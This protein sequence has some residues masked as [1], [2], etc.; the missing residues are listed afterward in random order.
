MRRWYPS[1][2]PVA[3]LVV[4]AALLS[5]LLLFPLIPGSGFHDN[6]RIVE[7]FCSITVIIVFAVYLVRNR[8]VNR[9]GD[10]FLIGLLAIFFVLGLVSSLFAYST[11]HA[12]FEWANSLSLFGMS[13]FIAREMLRKGDVFLDQILR[14]CGIGCVF[15]IFVEAVVYAVLIASGKQPPNG[16]LIFGFDNYRFFNHVQTVTLPLLCLWVSRTDSGG[17][18]MFAW[19]V[20]SIWWTLLFLSTGRGTFIGVLA[21]VCVTLFYFRK[22]AFPWCRLMLWTALAGLGLYF[23]FYV[24]VPISLGLQPFGFLFSVVDRTIENPA[25]SRWPLWRRAWEMTLAHP[26]LGAG[27]LHFAHYGRDV[28]IGAHPHNWVLQI[29]SEWGIPALICL[30][31][32]IALGLKKLLAVREHLEPTD[33]KNYLTLAALLTIAVAILVDG[34]VSG[35]IVMP[36]SQLWIVLYVGCAWGWVASMTQVKA[37]TTMRLFPAMRIG[38]L[39][40]AVMLIYFLGVGL[41]PEIGNLPFYEEKNLQKDIYTN[42]VYRPRIWLGGYF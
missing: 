27:P 6:Q 29:A 37:A 22:T 28:Q 35:L 17:K 16:A 30:M 21:G 23:L 13:C 20:A 19:S 5:P 26:W 14:L 33:S 32:A 24:L 7:V 42:P 2:F 11:R 3:Y 38:G 18:K 15:Y 4:V 8:L 25:S 1:T 41:W 34:L 31:T 39:I 12:L 36:T 9:P 40:G 10:F